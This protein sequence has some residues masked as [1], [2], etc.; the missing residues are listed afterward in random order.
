[1]LFASWRVRARFRGHRRRGRRAAAASSLAVLRFRWTRLA[2]TWRG[3]GR[4]ALVAALGAILTCALVTGLLGFGG[5]GAAPARADSA[6]IG[7]TMGLQSTAT[8]QSGNTWQYQIAVS[9]QG[10]VG[11]TCDD[12]T[13]TIPMPPDFA[14]SGAASPSEWRVSIAGTDATLV[15]TGVTISGNNW[16]VT[17]LRPM[18]AGESTVFSFY[19]IPPN[20]T[21]PNGA[22][23]TLSAT[24][25]GSNVASVTTPATAR[26]TA[27]ATATCRLNANNAGTGYPAG[28]TQTYSVTL[29]PYAAGASNSVGTLAADPNATPSSLSFPVPAGFTFVSAQPINGVAAVYNS[30]TRVVTWSPVIASVWTASGGA[31]VYNV[32]STYTGYVTLTLPATAGSY[33]SSP[34]AQ[35]TA[36]GNSSP[37]NCSVAMSMPVTSAAIVGQ[38]MAKQ[39]VGVSQFGSEQAG[40]SSSGT[41]LYARSARDGVMPGTFTSISNFT[42]YLYRNNGT[43]QAHVYDGL[44]CLTSGTGTTVSTPYAS[45]PEGTLCTSP[46]F[47]LVQINLG[48]AANALDGQVVKVGFTDGT[49]VVLPNTGTWVVPAGMTAAWVTID[50]AYNVNDTA[51]VKSWLLSGWPVVSGPTSSA[52]YVRNTA[53]V[54]GTAT[55]TGT[56]FTT[57]TAYVGLQTTATTTLLLNPPKTST[58]SWTATWTGNQL[59]QPLRP[60]DAAT[61]TGTVGALSTDPSLATQQRYAVVIPANSGINVTGVTGYIGNATGSYTSVAPTVTA[62]YNGLGDTLYL[63]SGATQTMVGSGAQLNFGGMAPGV[64]EYYTYAGF[65]NNPTLS[66]NGAS[67]T[68]GGGVLVT[69][70]TGI[71]GPVGVSTT[72]CKSTNTI[73]VTSPGGGL[74]LTKSVSDVTAGTSFLGSP[75]VVPAASGDTVQFRVRIANVGTSALTNLVLY[76]VLPYPGDTGVVDGQVGV[77]RGSTRQPVL[78][79][80]SVPTGWTVTYTNVTNPCRSEVGV[81]TGCTTVAWSSV[82]PATTGALRLTSSSL[83]VGSYVDILLTYPAPAAASWQVDDV[84]WNSVGG[85][86][87]QGALQLPPVEA[88]KV[89]FGYPSAKLEWTKTDSE[90]NPLAGAT[91]HVTGPNGYAKD[92]TDNQAP[93]ADP[94]DGGFLLN[95]GLAP[96]T[97]TITETGAPSG[98]AVDPTPQSVTIDAM[99]GTGKVGPFINVALASFS[100]VKSAD[101]PSVSAVGDPVAWSVLVTNTGG[102]ALTAVDVAEAAFSGAGGPSG[103]HLDCGGGSSVIASL[104]VGGSVTC[105]ASYATVRADLLAGTIV[106]QA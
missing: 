4:G 71:I 84:A 55:L 56:P 65:A 8:Q 43:Y 1:M 86:A 96:G 80:V 52:Q 105:H 69:D 87:V 104:P 26:A 45:L 20:G 33:S 98:F 31:G 103:L 74:V 21:T 58:F 36:I 79:S 19:V 100:I 92:V 29:Y 76:D 34:T 59:M 7:A 6:T 53:T 97:Y 70:T 14:A 47:R 35:F 99:G 50:G 73:I 88:P 102:S 25:A 2:R 54:S 64:Y 11:L 75:A 94:T 9:C 42:I 28:S 5:F 85:T 24:V 17:F 10:T 51:T 91:F 72:L 93:D 60:S 22:S 12:M 16:V 62:D 83:A 49:S 106:N 95:K 15:P 38:I 27:T 90:N 30:A 32:A 68:A 63:V 40:T 18:S 44:P 101:V 61:T 23:W 57:G 77:A 66:D 41:G 67:C 48:A 3:Y 78:S 39:A 89:G 37:T 81:T 13:V 46:A 82:K